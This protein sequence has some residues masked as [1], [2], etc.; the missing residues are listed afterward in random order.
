M[1]VRSRRP[2][3]FHSLLGCRGLAWLPA[4][5]PAGIVHSA[6]AQ[7]VVTGGD[8]ATVITAADLETAGTL[9]FVQGNGDPGILQVT[10]SGTFTNS[11]SMT[12]AIGLFNLTGTSL[13]I[14]SAVPHAGNTATGT[15]TIGVQGGTL[16][17][18]QNSFLTG[19]TGTLQVSG[20]GTLV[21]EQVDWLTNTTLVGLN[22]NAGT[23]TFTWGGSTAATYAGALDFSTGA[24]PGEVVISTTQDTGTLA[25]TGFVS[26]SSD[27]RL[28]HAT[29]VTATP[30]ITLGLTGGF[31]GRT[32]I[33]TA[34]VRIDTQASIGSL[35]LTLDGA[36]LTAG[37]ALTI[38]ATQTLVIDAAST[39]VGAS[40]VT[41]LTIDGEMQG[42][43][44]LTLDAMDVTINGAT[45]TYTGAVSLRGSSALTVSNGAWLASA[46]GI[47]M[48]ADG[49]ATTFTW[50]SADDVTF[51]GALDVGTG[52]IAT[53]ATTQDTGSITL[54]G[55]VSGTADLGLVHTSVT[56]DPTFILA[57]TGGFTGRTVIETA[58]VRIDTQAS[59]GSQG[60][61]L[62]GATLTAGTALTLGAG[63]NL[64]VSDPSTIVGTG[65]GGALTAFTVDGEMQG[66]GEL[67]LDGISMSVNGTTTAYSGNVALAGGS[68]LSVSNGAWLAAVGTISMNDDGAATSFT[69]TGTSAGSFGGTLEVGAGTATVSTTENFTLNGT[70]TGTGN[71]LVTRS[72]GSTAEVGL[73]F[74]ASTL[75]GT[76]II[77]NTAA[78]LLTATS[79][80]DAGLTLTGGN[81]VVDAAVGS[82]TIGAAQDFTV[83]G[84]SSIEG[85]GGASALTLDGEMAGSGTLTVTDIAM[86]VNGTTSAFTGGVT[87]GTGSSLTV[88]NA[89]WLQGVGALN[90]DASATVDYTG[91]TAETYDGAIRLSTDPLAP[92]DATFRTSG[93]GAGALTLSG[94][95]SGTGDLVVSTT[96]G[97]TAGITLALTG[98]FTGSTIV[99]DAD[100]TINTQN[101]VGSAGLE[102][103][104]L[105]ATT[106]NATVGTALSFGNSQSLTIAGTVNL[107]GSAANS[108]INAQGGLRSLSAATLNLDDIALTVGDG[109]AST[110]TGDVSLTDGASFILDGAILSGTDVTSIVSGDTVTFGG[111]GT[112]G[113]IGDGGTF[114]GTLRLGDEGVSAT[115]VLNVTGSASLAAAAILQSHLLES[116]GTGTGTADKL[117]LGGSF[118]AGGA[119]A[120]L[121][122]DPA[123]FTGT[124][125]PVP[126]QTVTYTVIDATGGV[127]GSFGAVNLVT[128]DP[129]TGLPT[130]RP[131]NPETDFLGGTF[132]FDYSG[133]TFTMAVQGFG[134]PG[135]LPV[136]G[137]TDT[138]VVVPVQVGSS[139]I[140]RNANVGIAQNAQINASAIAMNALAA[141]PLAPADDR[142]VASQLLLQSDAAAYASAVVAVSAPTNPQALPTT[143][144]L[145]MF[146]AN[147]VAMKRLMQLRPRSAAAAPEPAAPRQRG[148]GGP[149]STA[150][151]SRTATPKWQ[152]F[153]AELNGPTPDEGI[154]GWARG[155][156]WTASFGNQG[157]AQTSYDSTFGN[158]A[159]GAD[160]VVGDGGILGGFVGYVPGSVNVTGG[161][162]DES[163]TINGINFGAYGSWV[164][165]RDNW[166]LSG[167]VSGAVASVDR[168]R[169]LYIPG[170]VRTATASSNAWS[171]SATAETGINLR[172]GGDS[173]LSPYVRAAYAFLSQGSYNESGAGSMDLSVGEQQGSGL[174]PSV[175]VRYMDGIR[176]GRSVIT[177]FVGGGFTAFVPLGD[178]SVTA[179]NVFS[180]L[181]QI[182][183]YGSGPDTLWGGTVEAGVE[184][185]LPEGFTF[186]ASF[187]AMFLSDAQV[188]GGQ[189]GFVIP[190]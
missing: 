39:I 95:A 56:A 102:L 63:Q 188:Y 5:I 34:N 183:V 82:L 26:G 127:T 132:S 146:E 24:T 7:T 101:S 176:S 51:A 175:G 38:G 154:R 15:C 80:G 163:M 36:T 33:D 178:W 106:L 71:L 187:N 87:L 53:I 158:A 108:A 88:A 85:T 18:G 156:G 167:A 93:A 86:N 153:G 35:G 144:M 47:S 64:V 62:D 73:G 66:T 157:W 155:F 174:Q 17:L 79:I 131:L 30:V 164:P 109:T 190:F 126:G 161:L 141:D 107:S 83:N 103:N 23:S 43:G 1:D 147:D 77:S 129:V 177:P 105:T 96:A 9:S 50:D 162:V 28:Q 55:A 117:S 142:F 44:N 42:S 143:F 121:I 184:W 97:S 57:L 81:L 59:I 65:T 182:N 149:Q 70:L 29:G 14:A 78:R 173:Y 72:A 170:A 94:F 180:G 52:G 61:T 185:A 99:N 98:T 67:T 120:N 159:V 92:A 89:A 19:F 100:V 172:C 84:V 115:S 111:I 140:N 2:V 151:A 3:F 20:L 166:Y 74:T 45:S 165:N 168:T 128:I 25:L 6:L 49:T 171:L 46:T 114:S 139:T 135:P 41:S 16:T 112:I 130:T 10:T 150:V 160:A 138:N 179:T 90:F 58:N 75:S 104:D 68:A 125:I 134:G 136:P 186:Y 189:V 76:T 123:V 60:L 69:Y 169:S 54:S 148:T 113:S 116:T 118:A 48:N 137:T 11:W 122:Y 40:G 124:L 181:P 13:T 119:T 91:T 31:A 110:F 152:A 12:D 8:P 22:S 145:G 37:T 133:N 4:V 27:L 32:I 21:V